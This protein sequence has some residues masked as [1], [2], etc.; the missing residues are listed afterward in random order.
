VDFRAALEQAEFESADSDARALRGELKRA[1]AALK[2][3][4][5]KDYYKI[6]VPRDCNE[7]DIKK[8]VPARVVQASSGQ[9]ACINPPCWHTEKGWELSLF[10]K[11]G[12]EEKFKLVVEAHAVLSDPHRR[13]RYDLG[14]DE[15]DMTESSHVRGGGGMHPDLASVFAQF[16]AGPG[17]GRANSSQTPHVVSLQSRH[18]PI[19]GFRASQH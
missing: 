6:L 19:H 16:S 2:R 9:G 13:E 11:G 10:F 15:D 14:E 3:S 17:G 1:E 7:A 8:G 5:A 12:D 4:K 18:L